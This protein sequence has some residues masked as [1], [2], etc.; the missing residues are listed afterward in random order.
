M[1][2]VLL[3]LAGASAFAV[4]TVVQHRAA[5][6]TVGPQGVR[7]LGRLLRRR[8]WLAAQAASGLGVVLH[9]AA[10]RTGA[11]VLVQ[12]LL[13]SGL[14]LSLALGAAV[15][16]RHPGR[17][18]PDRLQWVAAGAAAVGLTAFLLAARPTRGLAVAHAAPL[19]ACT[20][21]ALAVGGVAALWARRPDRPHRALVLGVGA[22]VGFGVNGLLLKQLLGVP[23]PSWAAG[24]GLLE[25]L[26]VA[27]CAV[28]LAQWGFQAGALIESLPAATVLEP[29]LCVLLAGPV[30][31]ESLA[32][33]AVASAAQ[34]A[35]AVLLAGGLLVV[36]RRSDGSASGT[37]AGHREPAQAALR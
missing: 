2:T 10:L 13:A 34:L 15:D 22:G 17:P 3:A 35:G 27:I 7:L 29:A 26:A 16:R 36:A 19:V 37:N 28:V 18:L 1:I 12:P 25:L 8:T 23:L 20:V 4:G 21:A 14:L 33:G 5:A 11:V 31:G 32:R 9:A 24:I 6:E 30:F